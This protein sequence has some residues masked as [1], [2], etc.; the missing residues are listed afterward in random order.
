MLQE[1]S[2]LMEPTPKYTD[3]GQRIFTNLQDSMWLERTTVR[4]QLSL[5]LLAA[6]SLQASAAWAAAAL[7]AQRSH[8]RQRAGCSAGCPRPQRLR[9][10]IFPVQ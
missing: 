10:A 5:A 4:M 9:P 1:G 6:A 2:C 8:T 3:D 7:S